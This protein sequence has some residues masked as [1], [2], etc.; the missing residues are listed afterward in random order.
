MAK[1][2]WWQDIAT[3]EAC[4]LSGY[5]QIKTRSANEVSTRMYENK[6][7]KI[8]AGIKLGDSHAGEAPQTPKHMISQRG[9]GA[10][11]NST[12]MCRREAAGTQANVWPNKGG[13]ANTPESVAHDRAQTKRIRLN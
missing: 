12:S 9:S 4:E 7:P 6:G 3:M 2:D 13:G 8:A 5:Q 1:K 10:Q 11:I